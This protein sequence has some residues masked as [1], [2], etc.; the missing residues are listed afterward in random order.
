[1][2]G[3]D[4]VSSQASQIS[5]Q[6]ANG[7][8]GKKLTPTRFELVPPKRPGMYGKVTLPWRLRPLGQS[9]NSCW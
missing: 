6:N 5:D 2:I 9:A 7:K 3:M 1:M 8:R 4:E